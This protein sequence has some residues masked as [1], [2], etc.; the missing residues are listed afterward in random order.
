MP[1][2]H[3]GVHTS[4]AQ[5]S[6]TRA[7]LS[8]GCR[9]HVQN[10]G[11]E[12]HTG[13]AEAPGAAGETPTV[14]GQQQPQQGSRSRSSSRSSRPAPISSAAWPPRSSSKRMSASGDLSLHSSHTSCQ[15][16]CA[17]AG[18]ESQADIISHAH[19]SLFLCL[20]CKSTNSSPKHHSEH[21]P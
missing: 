10:S 15:S 7:W 9:A 14:A 13:P 12:T 19:I 18:K 17:R 6:W 4:A 3:W 2:A 11:P 16:R 20:G 5:W 1:C 21:Q 8:K